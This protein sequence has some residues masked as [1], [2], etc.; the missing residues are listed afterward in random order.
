MRVIT[1]KLLLLCTICS[2]ASAAFRLPDSGQINCYDTIGTAI[3]C[4]GTGQDGAYSIN[5]MS[6][7]DNSNGTVID[8]ITGLI[9]Q[10]EDDNK[11]YNWYLASGTYDA[12]YNPS[13]DNTCSALNIGGISEWRLPS[14]KELIT[15]VDYGVSYPGP[16]INSSFFPNTKASS[17]CSSTKYAGIPGSSWTVSFND[18]I[19]NYGLIKDLNC[20]V[21]CVHGEQSAQSLTD[22]G[23]GTVT[24]SKTGLIWQ[25]GEPGLMG[26]DQALSYCAELPLGNFSDWRLPNVKELE[27]L[28]D[29]TRKSPA[30]NTSFFPD[31]F[32]SYFYMS[33]TSGSFFGWYNNW[34]AVIDSGRITVGDKG[35]LGYARCVRGGLSSLSISKTGSGTGSV[36]ADSGAINWSDSTGTV[37]Y[38]FG[39]KIILSPNPDS[40]SLFGGWSSDECIGTGNCIV[41]M[42]SDVQV[43]ALFNLKPVRI[44]GS[45]PT[46]FNAFNEL[47]SKAVGGETVEAAGIDF[48]EI[49]NVSKPLI[50][51]GGF[52]SSYSCNNGFTSLSGLIIKDGSLTVKNLI[53]K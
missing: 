8:N 34:S 19:L 43:T 26:W 14:K 30:I 53:I 32:A 31:A 21:R 4:A 28:T 16:T 41:T 11:T 20:Y 13:S 10:K 50:F 52:D 37:N 5:L 1:F 2:T 22:N 39:S 51:I 38:T 47:H 40:S 12:E 3:S 24:D 46:Y 48:S 36:N 42:T 27:S 49:L 17:Y 29:D 9:W 15:I 35:F 6:Y 7:T 23:N 25:Q 33:S 44:A 45:T 18:G